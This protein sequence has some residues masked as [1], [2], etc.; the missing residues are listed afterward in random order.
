[1]KQ[2]VSVRMVREAPLLSDEKIQN[3]QDAIRILGAAFKDYDREV[4]GVVHLRSYNVPINMTIVSM[5]C[6]NQSIVHSRELLKVAEKEAEKYGYK[7]P[8]ASKPKKSIK[9]SLA[10][11]KKLTQGNQIKASGIKRTKAQEL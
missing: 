2:Q 9:A 1:M 11:K 5:G 7:K 4:V 6:L 10:E 8:E 3:P